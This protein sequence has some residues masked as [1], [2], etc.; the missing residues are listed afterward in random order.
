MGCAI[1]MRGCHL[2]VTEDQDPFA[3]RRPVFSWSLLIRWDSNA[4]PDLGNGMLD[5]TQFNRPLAATQP[6]RKKLPDMQTVIA[7]GLQASLRV[8]RLFDQRRIAPEMSS[9]IK[10][11]HC[12]KAPGIARAAR[13]MRGGNGIQFEYHVMRQSQNFETVN[14]HEGT[15]DVHALIPGRAITGHQ[16]FA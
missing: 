5:R 12:G 16:A 14:T 13:D 3:E 4:P 15:H 2:G 11:N 9:M 1:Q 7:L 8:R 10:R 6:Y